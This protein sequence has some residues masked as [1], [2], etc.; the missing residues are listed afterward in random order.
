LDNRHTIFGEVV[1]GADVLNKIT[2]RDPGTATDPGDTLYTVLIEETDSS[3]L[4]TP[5]PPT[6]PPTPFAPNSVDAQDR[7]LAQVPAAER[8]R[9][10]NTA[11]EMVIDPAQQY[12]AT[13]KTTKGDL[14]VELYA[15]AAPAAVNNFVALA[16]LGFYDGLPINANSPDNALIFGSPDNDARNDVGYRVQAELN[17]TGTLDIGSVT[18]MPFQEPTGEL[19]ASG[20]QILIARIVPPAEANAQFSFFGKVVAGSEVLAELTPEDTI[21]SIIITESE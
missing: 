16:N 7:P 14:V 1:E 9:Y 15:D 19:I 11:P 4:P 20:S 3:T 2:R 8:V 17:L 21:E 18:Y 5:L 13:I 12:T 10:F 6:P